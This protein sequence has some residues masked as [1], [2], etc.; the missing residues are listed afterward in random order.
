ME[1]LFLSH[2]YNNYSLCEYLEWS[3]QK[4]RNAMQLWKE[5]FFHIYMF[6]P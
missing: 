1:E 3:W 5:Q 2:Q 4:N 6:R